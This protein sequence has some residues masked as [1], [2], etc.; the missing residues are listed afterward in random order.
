MDEVAARRRAGLVRRLREDGISDPSVLAAVG[1]VP[2]ERFVPAHLADEAY[3]YEPLPIGAGQTI[4]A[5][6]MVAF[7]TQALGLTARSRVLEVGTGSGYAAAV[8]SRCCARVLTIERHQGL[9]A[10]A[11]RRLDVLGYHNVEVR[12]GD[13]RLGAVDGAPFDAVVVT[14]M[15]TDGPPAELMDQLAPGGTLVCPVGGPAGGDLL[16]VRDGRHEVLGKVAFVPLVSG[17]SK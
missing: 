11:K 2:R 5:P 12:V 1:E 4:S 10:S 15:A 3:R 14:A 8:V 16:R 9:A 6:W 13:G 17:G 7:M